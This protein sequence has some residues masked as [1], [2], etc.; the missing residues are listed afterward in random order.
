MT[1]KQIITE[2]NVLKEDTV[3]AVFDQVQEL[4]QNPRFP[5]LV[6]TLFMARDMVLGR[7]EAAIYARTPDERTLDCGQLS[8]INAMLAALQSAVE[9]GEK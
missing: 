9:A 6:A 7:D 4:A 2:A 5:A 3:E 1:W 8:Q